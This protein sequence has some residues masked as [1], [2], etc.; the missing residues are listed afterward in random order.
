MDNSTDFNSLRGLSVFLLGMMGS[1][2]STLGE[3]LSRR[4][5]YRFFDTDILIERVAG[6]KIKEIFADEG[7]AT[8][9]ELETQV[10]AELS[11]LTKT[12]IATGGGMV[13]KPINWSY[14]RHGLMIWLDVPLEVLVKRLKQDTSRP[15]L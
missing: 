9:R 1:G 13:L 10:L 5:Q 14:L 4:L 11:S 2:K 12:V 3:L 8:F 7:E 15:L 6:K